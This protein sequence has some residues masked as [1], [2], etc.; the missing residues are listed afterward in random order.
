MDRHSV[1][2]G[3]APP[4]ALLGGLALVAAVAWVPIALGVWHDDGVYLLLGHALARG[5]GLRYL[6]VSGAPPAPKFPP[7]FPLVLSGVWKAFP[8]FPGNTPFFQILNL[9]LLVGAGMAF[10]GYARRA[11]DLPVWVALAGTALAWL[12][13]GLWA[14][15]VIPL[16]EP[17]FL[18]CLA[19]ALWAATGLERAEGRAIREMALFLGGFALVF[20]TRTVGAAVALGV[21][22]ALLMAGRIR[23]GLATAA[24]TALVALPWILWSRRAEGGVPE[25]LRGILGSYGGWFE[26]QV[27]GHPL[28]YGHR[29]VSRA[30]VLAWQLV[31]YLVPAGPEWFRWGVA[32]PVLP[33]LALG[34]VRMGARSRTTVWVLLVYVGV[35]WAWPYNDSRFLVPLIPWAI[36]AVV[37]AARTLVESPVARGGRWL[38]VAAPAVAGLWA[39]VFAGSSGWALATGVHAQPYRFRTERL[40][41][42]VRAVRR[43]TPPDAVVGAPELW[44][45]L[46]LYTG[47]T[48]APSAPFVASLTGEPTW[49]TPMEQYRLWRSAGVD[50][51]LVEH[52][53][54][55]H[56]K[57]LDRLD[58]VCPNGAVAVLSIMKGQILVRL[59]WDEACRR[60]LGL[61]D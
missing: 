54:E 25:P 44:A 37:V 45:A 49:G 50:H 35:L 27:V 32:L 55:V 26:E 7:L 1:G 2:S 42:A 43:L 17:L 51:L 14:V 21:V 48:V 5:E 12:S 4:L 34:L 15:A 31:H 36:L 23:R 61:E 46:Y 19:L 33:L 20:H 30:G 13:T 10:Y 56:G 59:D 9:G 41:E 28:A 40:Q 22:L 47:R 38:H 57:A 11:L 29:L 53:G 39:L 3:L 52:G 18:L 8:D 60:R 58:A 16:S 6:G 24:G